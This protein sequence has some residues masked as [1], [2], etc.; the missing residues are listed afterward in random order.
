MNRSHGLTCQW[1][2]ISINGLDVIFGRLQEPFAIDHNDDKEV[3]FIIQK[4]S[5][6]QK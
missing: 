6:V 4:I 5:E 1:H 2:I 3:F